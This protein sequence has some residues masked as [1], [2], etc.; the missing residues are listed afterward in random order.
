MADNMTELKLAYG[1]AFEDLYST[2]GLVKVDGNFVEYLGAKD[3][4]LAGRLAAARK[5]PDDMDNKAVSELML[6]LAPHLDTFCGD[7]F[8]IQKELAALKDEYNALD[9]FFEAKRTW[10]P[11]KAMRAYK[12]D[13]AEGFDGP[14]LEAE[15]AKLLGGEFE[16]IAFANK[17]TEWQEDAE[18]NADNLDLA[19]RY[20]AWAT[21]TE[22]GKA[23]AEDMTLFTRPGKMNFDYLVPF[24]EGEWAGVATKEIPEGKGYYPREGFHLTDK[25][26]DTFGALDEINYCT[27]CHE[28]DKD[29]CR[30]G[31]PDKKGGKKYATNPLRVSLEGCPLEQR[32]SESHDVFRQGYSVGALGII[33]VD[34]PMVA[35]TGH[36][37]CNDCMKSCTFQKQTP[38]NIPEA[39]SR[40]L[41]NVMHLPWG[42]EVYSLLTRW[43]PLNFA[44]PTPAAA[45]DYKVLV[46]GLGPAGY[47]LAHFLLNEGHT[48]AAIDGLKLEPMDPE[49]SGVDQLGNPVAFKPIL[50][51]ETLWEP[52]DD[53][54]QWGFGGVAEYGITIR[55]DK[56]FL[57]ILRLLVERRRS[58]SMFGGVRFGS[59][60]TK[61][62]AFEM[63][64]DHIALCMGAGKP[65]AISVPNGLARGVRQASDFLMALQ[66]TGAAKKDSIANMQVRMPVITIG[67]GLTAM[68]AAVEALA[69]YVRQC[70]KFLER[71]ETLVA[72]DDEATVRAYW[73]DDEKEIADEFIEHGKAIKAEREKAAAEGRD[74]NFMPLLDSWG[75]STIAYRRKME[76]SP[77]YQLNDD[78][79]V[80]AFDQGMRFA[81]LLSPVGIEVDEHEHVKS[82]KLERQKLDESGRPQPAGEYVTMPARCVIVAAGTQPNTVLCREHPDFAELDGK[83]FQAI[84]EDGDK[85]TPPWTAKPDVPWILMKPEDNGLHMSFFGDLHPSWAGNVV[86]AMTSA[87]QGYPVINRT[88]KKKAP[89][90]V[91][92]KDLVDKL[93]VELRPVIKEVKRLTH[94][95]VA[96]T[97]KAP[98]G[99]ETHGPG[100]FYRL[101]NF[102]ANA[103]KVDGTTLA[104]EGVALTGALINRKE[105]EVTLVSYNAGGSTSIIPWLRP[106][107]PVILMGPTGA[108]TEVEPGET[109]LLAGGGVGNAV[110]M[111]MTKAFHEAGAKILYFAAYKEMGDRFFVEEIEGKSDVVVWSCDTGPGFT[112]NPDRPQD[113]T[114][115]GNIVEAMKAYNEGKLGEVKIPL[116]EVDRIIAIG[117]NIMMN[118]VGQARHGVLKG[119]FKDDHVGIASINSPMQC[120]L[121]EICAQCQQVHTDPKTGKDT[122]VYSCFNQDQPIDHVNFPSL[123]QRLCQNSVA[124]KLTQQWIAHCKMH[125]QTDIKPV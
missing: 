54:C 68:D 115:V 81:E 104:M 51:V 52:L 15:L 55:W 99:A 26:M 117:S 97:V 17:V 83:Y 73:K 89:T 44:M 121:K 110:L 49:I 6:A 98:M 118:A 14:A 88:L 19:M 125:V 28:R 79:I 120:M 90:S 59:T 41:K 29:S 60:I 53:R 34:N 70:E 5:A 113:M 122:I 48:V 43:N 124:E 13:E 4:D 25:G 92:P 39:E 47:T 119:V 31:L 69:Y 114:F 32:V 82:V 78:E 87:K 94:N 112:P 109:V 56:N 11:K 2:E 111:T 10:V 7:L 58:F 45:S 93:N 71:Y 101:Q 100:Q 74:T 22:A 62:T 50:D 72:E 16:Q 23:H 75:G 105:G 123:H 67:G 33:C 86:K 18:A 106:G 65:T 107:E 77:S 80:K 37:I 8:G 21:R 76:G 108:P 102:E 42:F 3:K 64:F 1:L 38:V 40:L 84:D 61:E 91:K 36:R 96:V 46:V 24:S 103:L 85:Q 9:G 27:L 30:S 116:G 63:G 66:L 12:A 35:G 57:T 95:V 20:A